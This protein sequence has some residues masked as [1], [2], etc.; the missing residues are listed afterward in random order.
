MKLNKFMILA[1]VL[2]TCFY[3]SPQIVGATPGEVK[4]RVIEEV[5]EENEDS[6]DLSDVTPSN[7]TADQSTPKID[8]PSEE[9]SRPEENSPKAEESEDKEETSVEQEE[10]TSDQQEEQISDEQEGQTSDQQEEQI[11]DEQEEQTSNQQDQQTKE[12]LVEYEPTKEGVTEERIESKEEDSEEKSSKEEQELNQLKTFSIQV[13]EAPFEKGDRHKDIVGIKKKLNRVGFGGITETYFFGSFTE[14]RVKQFQTYYG[15]SVTGKTDEATLKQLDEVYNSPFQK[16]KRHNDTLAIKEKLNRIGYGKITVT[17]F[18][19]TYMD[20]QVRKFQKDNGLRINGIMDE[21]TLRKLNAEVSE[22]PFQRGDRHKDIVGIKKKLNRVGF[23]GITETYFFG[24]FTEKRVKQFQTYYGLSVTGKTDEATLKQLDEV[25]NSPFQKGKRHND[26]LAI[27]EKLNRIGYGKITVTAFYGTY[28]DKQVRKFQ[29]D[30]GLRINGIMD[31]ITLRK[32][33]AEVSEIPFQRGD[34]HKDIVGI[35]KKL[36]RVGFG[37]ITETY[38]FG[39]FTE[40]R[41]KQFQTYYGLSVTGKTDEATLK[42]LDEVYNS[43]FQKGKRH[44][45]TLAIKEKLNRIGYG[46]I[47]VT[48]FYG[49]YMDKQVRKFQKDNGLRINGIMDEIT[50]RKLNAEVSEIPFQ[51]GDR[52]KD[53]V[54]IKKKLNRVGF[55]GITETYFFGS[56]TEKRVKQFQTYYGLSVTGKTDEATLKQLDE[57]YNSPFQKGKRH[58]DTLAIKEKLNRIGY[59]KI[60]VTAF[61][62]TYMDKQVRKFQKDNG[63]RIN[64]IMDEITL[65]KLNAEVSKTPFQRGDR[66]KDIVGIKKKLNRV[67]FG[68]ISETTLFGSWMETRVKQ[69]QS[70]YGLSATGKIDETTTK[71][72]DE[73]YNSPFQKGKRHSDVITLKQKLNEIGYGYISVT[74]LYGTFMD[75]QVRKFQENNGL[76]VN[77][78]VD[79]V[80]V[81]KINEFYNNRTIITYSNY[82]LT[83]EQA[84]NIQMAITNPPPQTDKYANSPAYISSK[85]VTLSQSGAIYSGGNV[86]VRTE[87][88]LNNTSHKYTLTPGTRVSILGTVKGDS[89]QGSTNWYKIEYNNEVLFAHS[90]LVVENATIAKTTANLNVRSAPNSNSDTHVYGTLAKGTEVNVIST[91]GNWYQ[92]SYN[93]WRNATRSDTEAY[94]NPDFN[95]EFQHLDLTSYAGASEAELNAFLKDKGI[96]EGMGKAFIEA[97]KKHNVN[98]LYLVSH[99]LLE[100][101]NGTSKLATGIKVNGKVVYNMFGIEAYDSCPESC[102]SAKAYAENW[103]T[104]YKA[105]VGGAEF[106][107][108]DYIHN[109]YQQNTIYKMRWNPSAMEATGV[110]GKQ[111]ATDIGWAVK[112][113]NN[114]KNMY[115]T[116]SNPLFKFNIVQY[117]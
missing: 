1:I 4:E 112:Q 98:E 91:T 58:N 12:G 93:A 6:G 15:L 48:A 80:T 87:P 56:F 68:G 14:K 96:L 117:K 57:V 99:A 59:G 74:T 39:S 62:G 69:F 17:A 9:E 92:I 108:E 40:K 23:G 53:I 24:S 5:S 100:T 110:F 44:N 78:I 79:E 42:Q 46:K 49:T 45:D 3:F 60:T 65:K 51:R 88:N 71:K 37:G 28:M 66:H 10:Q 55:G 2:L 27:K 82:N 19:G 38:F 7:N 104:P 89:Y 101:G 111:Y 114:L 97:S 26:T 33:N 83:L 85:Y 77:G 29:K 30:N 54:G 61:Y 115:S 41:V 52:H 16:G 20:K 94:L 43:P 36:N 22:I 18:Y 64:G 75:K 81:A 21:I 32:L 8:E 63:L 90:K 95:D 67:G 84:L 106:I 105:I 25:Y 47:T 31:E 70:Y 50:L 107:G 103:D 34:R 72:L 11:S 35:K 13:V 76:T 86:K 113:T 73:V 116:L 109:E 102:G